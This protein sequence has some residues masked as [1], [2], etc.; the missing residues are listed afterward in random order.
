MLLV[1]F[2]FS[3]D[4]FRL[5]RRVSAKLS[6]H[7]CLYSLKLFAVLFKELQSGVQTP[8]QNSIIL[9]SLGELGP[10]VILEQ[11]DDLIGLTVA[12]VT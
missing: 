5:F 6:S 1:L 2:L 8:L 7:Y 3:C 12:M 9:T 4:D 10:P 11:G